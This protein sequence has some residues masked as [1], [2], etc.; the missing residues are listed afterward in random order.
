MERK[1]GDHASGYMIDTESAAEMMRLTV[2]DRLTTASIGGWFPEHG[3]LQEVQHTL[4][5]ACGPGAWTTE[6]AYHYPGMQ[7]TGFDIS[8]RMIRYAQT[9]AQVQDLP[10]AHFLV[11]DATTPLP[12]A[13]HTFDLVNARFIATFMPKEA[14]PQLMQE[15]VRVARPGG[16]IRLTECDGVGVSNSYAV[17]KFERV[18]ARAVY[19][20]GRSFSPYRDGH[21]FAITPMLELFLR[22]AG[23][24]QIQKRAYAHDFSA[25]TQANLATYENYKVAMQLALP[26]LV[27]TGVL[28]ETEGEQLY[29]QL[30]VEMLDSSFRA[31][32]YL[33]SVWGR[34]PD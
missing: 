21:L 7:V 17:E 5:V 24:Q 16:I 4:D 31:I 10:N 18:F 13:D 12:F 26:A 9:Q 2:L 19:L 27:R 6:L 22:E 23:C 29:E 20:G 34:I 11:H 30:L 32:L 1:S 3:A 15:C 25:G 14:W 28:S 33:L 8:Q